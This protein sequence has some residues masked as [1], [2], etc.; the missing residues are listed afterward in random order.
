VITHEV[1]RALADR[2]RTGSL[3]GHRDDGMRIALG[4]EGGGMRGT[5]SA[6]MAL[7]L[8]ELG[9]VPSFDAVYG[10]S[11]GAITGAWLLSSRPGAARLGRAVLREGADPLVRAAARPPGRGHP[12]AG[13]GGVPDGVPD[14]FRLGAGQP[15]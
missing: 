1:L 14:G 12:R 7:A 8:H 13:R 9:L 5:I 4:I 15:G 2:A 6:G 10:A 11:A 3:P